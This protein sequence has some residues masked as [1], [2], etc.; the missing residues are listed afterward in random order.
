M[1]TAV[2]RDYRLE[3]AGSRRAGLGRLEC[4]SMKRR[5]G[6]KA[7]PTSLPIGF[8]SAF[9]WNELGIDLGEW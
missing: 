5:A 2:L 1:A 3:G 4:A 9:A 7:D 8:E 6:H